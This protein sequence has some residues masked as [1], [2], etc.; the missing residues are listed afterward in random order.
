[1]ALL[2]FRLSNFRL[3][4]AQTE[5][6]TLFEKNRFFSRLEKAIRRGEKLF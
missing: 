1:M 5:M 4:L 2:N 3:F 6:E